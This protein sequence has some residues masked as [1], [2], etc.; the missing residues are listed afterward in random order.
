MIV[1][2][3]CH[4]A[5]HASTLELVRLHWIVEHP[6]AYE[7]SQNGKRR[8]LYSRS[9]GKG[10]VVGRHASNLTDARQIS[11]SDPARVVSQFE[12]RRR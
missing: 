10:R 1:T 4:D 12:I 3:G 9:F 8:D 2:N 7:L 6:S 5:N 11:N